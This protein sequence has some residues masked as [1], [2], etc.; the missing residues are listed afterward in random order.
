MAKRDN[1]RAAKILA[2]AQLTGNDLQVV[3][4][5]GISLRTLYNYRAALAEDREL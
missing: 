2:E 1:E 3:E 5:H 4:R